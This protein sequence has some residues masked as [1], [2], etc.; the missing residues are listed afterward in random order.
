MKRH[1]QRSQTSRD[2]HLERATGVP[3]VRIAGNLAQK[4]PQTRARSPNLESGSGRRDL[5]TSAAS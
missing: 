2:T 1:T 3:G 5:R 4:N